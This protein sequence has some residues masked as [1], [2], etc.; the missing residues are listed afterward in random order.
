M[1]ENRI[2]EEAKTVTKVCLTLR[3]M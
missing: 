3:I 1:S 2:I